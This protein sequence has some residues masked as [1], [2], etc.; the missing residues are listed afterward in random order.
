MGGSRRPGTLGYY[1]DDE[2]EDL[3]DGTMIRARSLRPGPIGM[4]GNSTL[5]SHHLP[6]LMEQV[7]LSPVI[8]GNVQIIND[9]SAPMTWDSYWRMAYDRADKVLQAQANELLK[10]GNITKLEFEELVKARNTLVKEFRKPLSPFG[11]QYSEF[12][13]PASR[14]PQPGELLAKKGRI[15][16]VLESV[17]KSRAAVNRLSMVFR[18]A[19]PALV[20]LDITITTVV[21]MKAPPEQR[22]RV[23]AREYTGL[24]FGV[25]SGAGGA[26]AGCVAFAALGLPSL[27]LPV[28]GEVTE[29]TLCAVGG[30]LGGMGVGW[31]GREADLCWRF[32][33][34]DDPCRRRS[35]V[36]GQRGISGLERGRRCDRAVPARFA[37]LHRVGVA[38]VCRQI[39]SVSA[40]L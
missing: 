13:K 39:R 27:V 24:G 4:D 17:G 10:R 37:P 40:D 35:G 25:A 29:G 9:M 8:Q 38:A 6:S 36:R 28:I 19:G 21:V 30:I 5:S 15:E 22:G 2:G 33:L 23:T 26:W 20:V 3:N 14:L 11:K 16:A 32:F 18:F 12:L 1:D 7:L 34:S 31:V